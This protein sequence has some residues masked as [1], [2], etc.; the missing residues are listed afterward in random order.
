MSDLPTL[1]RLMAIRALDLMLKAPKGARDCLCPPDSEIGFAN[2][3]PSQ[4]PEQDEP[5]RKALIAPAAVAA[6]S[7]AGEGE[8]S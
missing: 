5:N 8:T 4:D 3:H 1:Y 7:V 2:V 6:G